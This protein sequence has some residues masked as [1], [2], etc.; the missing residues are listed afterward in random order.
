MADSADG[1]LTEAVTPL[2]AKNTD[3]AH[4]SSA[5]DGDNKFQKAISAWR[6]TRQS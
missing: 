2:T 1:S 5:Q 4:G 6:S 3:G